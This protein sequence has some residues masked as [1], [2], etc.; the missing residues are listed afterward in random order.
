MAAVV[1]VVVVEEVMMDHEEGCRRWVDEFWT[2][3]FEL[4]LL[5]FEQ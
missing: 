5:R 2:I 3:H 1:A 4:E